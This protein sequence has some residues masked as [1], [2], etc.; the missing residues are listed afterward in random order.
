MKEIGNRKQSDVSE[1]FKIHECGRYGLI[2]NPAEK[3]TCRIC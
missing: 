1:Y 3:E 2:A